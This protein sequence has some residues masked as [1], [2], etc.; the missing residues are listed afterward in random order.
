MTSRSRTFFKGAA[1][2][3]AA[4]LLL[5]WLFPA[6]VP[7]GA[8]GPVDGA[9]LPTLERIRRAGVA[10]VGFANE[11]PY[12]YLDPKTGRLTGES[13]EIARVVLERLGVAKIQGVLTEFGALIPG[14]KA[15]RFDVIAAGMYITPPRCAE[16][17]FSNP[18]YGIGEALVVRAG[19]PRGLHSY[20][21]VAARSDATLGVVTGA[22]E[23]EDALKSGI[24]PAQLQVFPDAITAL[25]AVSAGRVDAYGGTSLTVNTL[26]AHAANPALERAAPFTDPVIDGK[27]A[28]GY[29]AFAFRKSDDALRVAFDRELAQ[30]VGSAAHEALVKPFGFGPSELPGAATAAALCAPGKAK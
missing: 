20:A 14:L 24:R 21:D 28:R 4:V 16:V 5:L 2:G 23:R 10:R 19:N 9:A 11:A 29:G 15:G 1:F 25:E 30:F 18:T 8:R 6:L 13:P 7:G 27:T 3:A 17:A 26:L 12:A 22:I